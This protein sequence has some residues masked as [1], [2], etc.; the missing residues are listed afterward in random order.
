MPVMRV[1]AFLGFLFGVLAGCAGPETPSNH[2][3]RQVRG[4]LVRDRWPRNTEQCPQRATE[5]DR[6]R[7]GHHA[8]YRAGKPEA[9]MRALCKA[10]R[11]YRATRRSLDMVELSTGSLRQGPPAADGFAPSAQAA[12]QQPRPSRRGDTDRRAARD[13]RQSCQL[14]E[15]RPHTSRHPGARRVGR[16]RLVRSAGVVHPRQNLGPV[17]PPGLWLYLSGA[18][19]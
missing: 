12:Q 5:P 19:R 16:E 6:E 11:R 10:P 2:S 8:P 18:K 3:E 7:S 9:A 15:P 14:A 4:R 13:Y 1:A 17:D